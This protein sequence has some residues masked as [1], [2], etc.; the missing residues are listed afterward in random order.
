VEMTLV[1]AR[2]RL[3]SLQHLGPV[4]VADATVCQVIEHKV[5]A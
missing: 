2:N 1:D 5:P 3:N 4:P